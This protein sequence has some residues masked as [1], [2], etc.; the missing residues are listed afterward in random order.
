MIMKTR[1]INYISALL[2]IG[3]MLL[4]GAAWAQ[5]PALQYF[6]AND[7]KGL[8]VFETPKTDTV[9]FEGVRVRVGGDFA[10]QFQGLSQ[11]S[12]LPTASG[13]D[14]LQNL[15]SNFNL[16][17]ANL[18]L[19]IQLADGV[20]LHMRTY[21]SS[22]HHNEGWVKGGYLQ[23]DNLNFIREGFLGGLMEVATLR[24]GYNDINYGDLH[25]RRTDNGS[26]IYNAFVGNYIMDS[27]T[28]EPFGEVTVQK[29]GVLGVVGVTNGRLNQSTAEPVSGPSSLP[30]DG[31]GGPA[32]YLKLGY[33]KQLS[34]DLRVRLTGSY[35][36]S[37]DKSTREYLY[38]GDR[39]GAR[40]YEVFNRRGENNDFEPRLNPGWAYLSAFQ[41]N[42][43]VKF[44]GLEFFGVYEVTNNGDDAV[45]GK[46]TQTAAEVLY[47]FGGQENLYVGA[48]VNG[49]NGNATDAGEDRKI[50][51]QNFSFGWFMT[52]NILLKLE[53][54]NEKREGDG[55]LN[56]KYQDAKF[57]GF[58]I[59][60][61]ISF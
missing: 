29:N 43:F 36:N 46:Y 31:D 47:R 39:A 9:A 24:F 6:R 51:R 37:S 54:V 5:Q 16:P 28:T 11:S 32:F 17:S 1:T 25:F 42:P 48:R 10:I 18:N 4:S 56:T 27:F 19:D 60:A 40:Y 12:G 35:Y 23:I 59:E 57:D 38:G 52:D 20:R 33:D 21:L 30:G 7:K 15:E 3:L 22:R 2:L 34:D 13:I 26:A 55:W 41:I 58:M 53:Y 50:N 49:V 61:A 45:G 14:T 44:K 8:N